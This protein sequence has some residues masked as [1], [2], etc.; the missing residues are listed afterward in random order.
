MWFLSDPKSNLT[1]KEP[2]QHD[3]L[4]FPAHQITIKAHPKPIKQ[5][6]FYSI[7]YVEN[8]HLKNYAKNIPDLMWMIV[9]ILQ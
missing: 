5:N 9:I 3:I 7:H 1:K 4:E 8:V 6:L 2:T